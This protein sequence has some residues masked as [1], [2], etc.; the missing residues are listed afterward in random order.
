MKLVSPGPRCASRARCGV[1]S[2][3]AASLGLTLGACGPGV[4]TPVPEPPTLQL[5]HIGPPPQGGVSTSVGGGRQ[6]FGDV[7]AAPAG[8]LVRVTNL[9]RPD[10]VV[11][12]SVK[13][14][15]SF[16][17]KVEVLDGE[18]L[19][20]DWERG[21][22]QGAP[23]D[24]RFV[25]DAGAGDFHFEPSTRLACLKLTPGLALDFAT[26]NVQT[27]AVQNE[28]AAS[29]VIQNPRL[30]VG[31]ADF[32]LRTALPLTVALGQSVPLEVGFARSVAAAREDTLFFDVVSGGDTS[33]Y[34]ITL[35]APL[36]P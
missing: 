7:G 19:R 26:G 4:A 11:V 15:G 35:R 14:D 1:A 28:C 16:E 21:A 34:P 31:L 8:S 20:F 27:L 12:A 2:L 32:Q 17:L 29:V 30:R 25:D 24:A 3:L 9:E 33:R 18:E 13:S 23:Q 36:L 6:V 22:E 10:P 5:G